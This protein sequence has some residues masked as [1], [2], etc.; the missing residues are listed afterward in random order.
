MAHH[1]HE[2]FHELR[3][4]AVFFADGQGGSPNASEGVSGRRKIAPR[5]AAAGGTP[6]PRS[7]RRGRSRLHSDSEGAE[8]EEEQE[9][10]GR[11]KKKQ[12]QR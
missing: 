2:V 3:N 5:G 9:D 11:K 10:G 8:D 12:R 6:H 4:R 1:D 7:S